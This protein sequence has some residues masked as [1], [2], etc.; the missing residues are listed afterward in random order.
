MSLKRLI[1]GRCLSVSKSALFIPLLLIGAGVFPSYANTVT[2]RISQIRGVHG[3]IPSPPQQTRIDVTTPADL[4]RAVDQ[5]NRSGNCKIVLADGIYQLT[6][7][8]FIRGD[9]ISLVSASADYHKVTLRGLGMRRTPQTNNLIR[10]SGKYFTFSGITAEQAPN[11]IIQIA[12]EANADYATIENALL[13]DSFEQ[14]LK[15]SYRRETGVS[16]DQGKITNTTFAYSA[17]I[18]PQYYIGGIDL[19]GGQEWIIANNQFYGIASPQDRV[20]EHAIHIWNQSQNNLVQ[21]NVIINS[22]RGIGFGMTHRENHGGVIAQN[23]LFHFA[24]HPNADVGI[25][26]EMSP[27]T[28]IVNNVIILNQDYS[29]GIEYRYPNTQGV[30]IS[31]NRLN[32][33]IRARND[34]KANVSNNIR[35]LSITRTELE[36]AIIRFPKVY[37]ERILQQ[38]YNRQ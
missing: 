37:Q 2:E 21:N 20:A 26:A 6:N 24:D 3:Q 10:V 28:Q 23:T 8:L 7:T 32:K 35:Q 13:Q 16:A 29:N 27:G 33:A 17:G 4:Y 1:L 5:A 22:D 30:L 19:H 34:A 12:G 9:N 15:V 36:H 25:I 14:I 38:W 18:G 31:G 11:H